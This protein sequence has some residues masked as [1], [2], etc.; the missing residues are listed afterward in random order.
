MVPPHWVGYKMLWEIEEDWRHLV[1]EPS[2]VE[3]MTG[4]YHEELRNLARQGPPLQAHLGV[5]EELVAV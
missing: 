1:V 3:E 5:L 2:M 4:M